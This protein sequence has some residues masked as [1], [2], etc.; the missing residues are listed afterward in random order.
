MEP[1][2]RT[3]VHVEMCLY[4]RTHVLRNTYV[5]SKFLVAESKQNLM[6]VRKQ[7]NVALTV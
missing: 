4:V 7:I 5:F 2:V 6:K 1:Y 3:Y